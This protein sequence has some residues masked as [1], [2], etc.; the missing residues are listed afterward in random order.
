MI[1]AR[2]VLLSV[3]VFM[4]SCNPIAHKPKERITVVWE[5]THDIGLTKPTSVQTECKPKL[6]VLLVLPPPPYLSAACESD[7]AC[8]QEALFTHIEALT[9]TVKTYQAEY[10]SALANCQ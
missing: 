2:L 5:S 7:E 1:V 9:A 8:V 6:P 10:R 3:L 4:L